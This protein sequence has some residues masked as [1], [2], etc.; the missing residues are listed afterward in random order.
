MVVCGVNDEALF[1]GDTAAQRIATD[2]FGD[3]F[4]TCMDKSFTELD[5]EFKTYSDLT[6]NHL[7]QNQGQIRLLPGTKRMIKAFI[8]WVR[9]ERRLG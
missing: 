6:Q 4:V 3:D 1:D 7:T 5:S 2:L 8:Q 9:D